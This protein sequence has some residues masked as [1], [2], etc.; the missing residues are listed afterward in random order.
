MTTPTTKPRDAI[1]QLCV[2]VSKVID[3]IKASHIAI[4][5]TK[6]KLLLV[7]NDC[8]KAVGLLEKAQKKADKAK[9]AGKSGKAVKK[10]KEPYCRVP[11]PV[12]T[13]LPLKKSVNANPYSSATGKRGKVCGK[14]AFKRMPLTKGKR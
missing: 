14:A 13:P 6:A 1:E 3:Y 4:E 7:L 8:L 12:T 11:K 9:I 10:F 2:V 5:D